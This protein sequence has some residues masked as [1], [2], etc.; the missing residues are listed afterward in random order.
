MK[1]SL[2]KTIGPVKF[3]SKEEFA[4]VTNISDASNLSDYIVAGYYDYVGDFLM[5]FRGD[6]SFVQAPM[7]MFRNQPGKHPEANPEELELIDCGNTVKMGEYEASVR[8]ILRELDPVYDKKCR[9]NERKTRSGKKVP[10]KTA[11]KPRRKRI[12]RRK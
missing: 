10:R 6:N 3:L 5:L 4:E 9:A 2:P 12:H 11:A 1:N 8:G 7:S